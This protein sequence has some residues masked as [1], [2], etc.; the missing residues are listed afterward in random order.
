[1]IRDKE[2]M[3]HSQTAKPMV[4]GYTSLFSAILQRRATIVTFCLLQWMVIPFQDGSTVKGITFR[5][6]IL[7]RGDNFCD[8]LLASLDGCLLHS[9]YL[10][11]KMGQ[12]L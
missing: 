1:M 10:T 9:W 4:F 8:S 3:Q 2:T 12:L 11:L 6:T 5:G 7:Q